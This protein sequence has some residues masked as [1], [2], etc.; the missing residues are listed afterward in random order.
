MHGG[1]GTAR[2]C[3]G[4]DVL[5]AVVGSA[6]PRGS[7]LPWRL[8][9]RAAFPTARHRS[10]TQALL[11]SSR[12]FSLFLTAVAPRVSLQQGSHLS[13]HAAVFASLQAMQFSRHLKVLSK[14][15]KTQYKL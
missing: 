5:G 12:S 7:A 10:A 1:V 14:W 2:W 9:S 6:D 11:R 4:E 13:S 3:S 8:V 15:G